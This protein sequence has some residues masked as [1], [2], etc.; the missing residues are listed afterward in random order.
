MEI[1]GYLTTDQAA[2]RLGVNRQSVY[3]LANRAP[4]FP[5]P[6]KV[7]RASL[8]PEA[9]VDEWRAKHP[10]RQRKAK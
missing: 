10:A 3:N 5:K 6:V 7:G 2:E 8:W 4:D 9:A 1:P